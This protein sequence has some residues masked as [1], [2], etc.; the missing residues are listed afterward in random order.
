VS[1]MSKFGDSDRGMIQH[2]ARA[3]NAPYP[4]RDDRNRDGVNTIP[5][6]HD[7]GCTGPTLRE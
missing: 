4:V 2:P 3:V 5:V 1:G 6:N 7:A